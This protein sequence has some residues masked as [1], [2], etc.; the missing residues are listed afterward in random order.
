MN[1]PLN[2]QIF[3]Q[4]S[5]LWL[6]PL[7]LLA[8]AGICALVYV[9]QQAMLFPADRA[10]VIENH[11]K[12]AVG[13][14]TSEAFLDGSC[15]KLHAALWDV[16]DSKGIIMIFHGNAENM[17][18]VEKQV[19]DFHRLGYAVAAWDYPGYG[20][21]TGC[22]FDEQDLLMDA[23]KAF[24]WTQQ[25]AGGKPITLYGR[26][27]GTG[28]ALYIASQQPVQRVLLIS[29]YDSLAN[30][31]KDHMPPYIPV[32]WLILYPLHANE[33]IAKVQVPIHAIHGLKDTLIAPERAR[34]LMQHAGKNAD[35]TWVENAGH[36]AS[37]LFETADN[38]LAN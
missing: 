15:G 23:T 4:R 13:G 35:I 25:Q 34:Q 17:M 33:W 22:W 29:P 30:V 32:D 27:I 28:L 7:A 5:L 38:W 12:P 24:Y 36:H 26:S 6:L 14:K 2:K 11:W 31:G 8:Y 1:A 10:P 9:G 16:P 21:S 20:R 37:E 19:A 3:L 18:T